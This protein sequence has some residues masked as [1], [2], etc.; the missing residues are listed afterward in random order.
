MD[1]TFLL[2]QMIT[3]RHYLSD[4]YK[5]KIVTQTLL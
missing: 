4:A 1:A 2:I 5:Y 3:D